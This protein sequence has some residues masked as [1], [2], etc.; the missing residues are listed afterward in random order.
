MRRQLSITRSPAWAK[1]LGL[2]DAARLL[3]QTLEQ[4]YNADKKPTQLAEERLNR[5]AAC[6]GRLAPRSRSRFGHE[7]KTASSM[8]R[9]DRPH[10]FTGAA[11][12]LVQCMH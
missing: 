6:H 3:Q 11:S 2:N 4:E 1:Q 5:E 12:F 7:F 10:R 8:P 9:K